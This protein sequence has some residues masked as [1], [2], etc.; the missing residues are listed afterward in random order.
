VITRSCDG[1]NEITPGEPSCRLPAS[2]RH[3]G[4]ITLLAAASQK[5][6]L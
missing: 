1:G 3:I 6:W 2:S 4:S 5:N